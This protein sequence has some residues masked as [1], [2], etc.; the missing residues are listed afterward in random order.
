MNRGLYTNTPSVAVQVDIR[1][2]QE[3]LYRQRDRYIQC[4]HCHH[5]LFAVYN[6]TSGHIATKCKKCGQIT[7]FHISK[8]PLYEHCFH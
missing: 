2:A 8:A 7:A 1:P 3:G 5:K 4:P 6:D